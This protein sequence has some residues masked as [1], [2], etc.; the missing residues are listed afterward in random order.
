[1][2]R[3]DICENVVVLEGLVNVVSVG[4]TFG[5]PPDHEQ[6]ARKEG[7]VPKEA[8]TSIHHEFSNRQYKDARQSK[9]QAGDIKRQMSF[10]LP[11]PLHFPYP[12]KFKIN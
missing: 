8:T 2:S 4:A 6:D 3:E 12:V 10:S 11:F 5:D 1:M 7:W 9:F